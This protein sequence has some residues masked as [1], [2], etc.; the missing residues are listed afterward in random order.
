LVSMIW[1]WNFVVFTICGAMTL[2][3]WLIDRYGDQ[4]K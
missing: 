1:F 3:A 2:A 4:R